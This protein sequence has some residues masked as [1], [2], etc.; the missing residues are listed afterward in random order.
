[1]TVVVCLFMEGARRRLKPWFKITPSIAVK[2]EA[3]RPM[4]RE[5]QR[6]ERSQL[7]EPGRIWRGENEG[8]GDVSNKTTAFAENM[9]VFGIDVFHPP[10]PT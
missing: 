2:Q 1:M 6:I 3:E 10:R 7:G 9:A 8:E 5:I 4:L